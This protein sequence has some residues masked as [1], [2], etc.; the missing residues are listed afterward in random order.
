[1]NPTI[2]NEPLRLVAFVVLLVAAIAT[3]TLAQSSE[4]SREPILRI[5]TGM[6]S[7]PIKRIGVDD[8][9]KFAEA[10]PGNERSIQR[11][12]GLL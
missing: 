11:P 6:H 1:M 2:N 9:I 10:D 8:R 3:C 12:K 5:E 7:A 4:P